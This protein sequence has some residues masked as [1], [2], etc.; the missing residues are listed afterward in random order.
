M[1][2]SSVGAA[3]TAIVA[4]Q[5]HVRCRSYGASAEGMRWAIKIWLLRSMILFETFVLFCSIQKSGPATDPSTERSLSRQPRNAWR[6]LTD[7]QGLIPTAL[8]DREAATV[9]LAQ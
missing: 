5:I 4:R 2:A 6:P 3:Y 1:R 8:I 9:R 7:E